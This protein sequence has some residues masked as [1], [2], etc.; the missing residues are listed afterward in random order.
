[1]LN[2]PTFGSLQAQLI[3][4]SRD[5]TAIDGDVAYTGAG[6]R[7]VAVI[8]FGRR[9]PSQATPSWSVG[10]GD[11]SLAEMLIMQ[12]VEVGQLTNG[13]DATFIVY[14]RIDGTKYSYAT[15]KSLDADGFTL[16]WTTVGV[17]T[18]HVGDFGALCLGLT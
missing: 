7:P 4:F 17:L 3:N 18:G 14:L 9:S 1:M 2:N 5:L 16:T 13:F 10:F 8:I 15:L 11:K 12:Y 6:C